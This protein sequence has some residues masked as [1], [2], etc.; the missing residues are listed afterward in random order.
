M[1][2]R[3]T[4]GYHLVK[5]GY[6]LWLPGDDRGHWSDAWD[7]QIG[8]VEPH[9]LHAGDP[10]RRRMAA[11]R[12]KHPAVGL[13]DRMITA[14]AAALGELVDRSDGG[15]RIAAAAIEPTHMHLQLT[16]TGRDID[17]TAMWIAD[18]T[19]KAV[20]RATDH[21]GPVWCKGRWR[22]FIFDADRWKRTTEYIRRHNRRAGRR[23][24]PYPWIT[25][26]SM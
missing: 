9:T 5:S 11:E 7:E 1:G 15:L 10:V 2:M 3:R 17:V 21:S 14:I 6:G 25:P 19:T 16:Y 8:Y 22:S 4:L 18:Q 23:D 26:L 24:D 20:H 12:M 13:T